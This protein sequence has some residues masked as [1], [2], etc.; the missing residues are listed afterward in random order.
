MR[1]HL[2]LCYS[3]FSWA[4]LLYTLRHARLSFQRPLATISPTKIVWDQYLYTL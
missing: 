1:A 3:D 2:V 4:L